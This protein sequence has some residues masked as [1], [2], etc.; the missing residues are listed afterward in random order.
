MEIRNLIKFIKE[1]IEE[2]FGPFSKE[3]KFKTSS[4]ELEITISK[5]TINER[6]NIILRYKKF[7]TEEEKGED[8]I[9]KVFDIGTSIYRK[10]TDEKKTL[11]CPRIHPTI[12]VERENY[13]NYESALKKFYE[14]IKEKSNENWEL[15][16]SA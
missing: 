12:L 13:G 2:K 5:N 1:N 14:I 15:V 16:E 6:P 8:I 7:P 9:I 4:S 11:T 10:W 3:F